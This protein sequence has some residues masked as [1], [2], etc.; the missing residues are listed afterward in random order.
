MSAAFTPPP[1]QLRAGDYVMS[2]P[3][4]RP[5]DRD[6]ARMVM[7]RNGCRAIRFELHGAC[8]RVVD[9]KTQELKQEAVPG[10]LVAHGYIGR[11]QGPG[12]EDL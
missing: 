7:R 12:V 4:E 9:H 2:F 1:T 10:T 5:G 11:M 3:I 8:D 6:A